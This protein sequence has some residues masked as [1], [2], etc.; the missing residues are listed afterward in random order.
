MKHINTIYKSSYIIRVYSYDD[1]FAVTVRDAKDELL[2]SAYGFES[3]EAA[4][5]EVEKNF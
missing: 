3:Q 4:E 1:Q 2:E 5:A